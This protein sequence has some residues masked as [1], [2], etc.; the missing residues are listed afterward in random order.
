MNDFGEMLRSIGYFHKKNI[1]ASN[2]LLIKGVA[3]DN[4]M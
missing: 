4:I 3:F 1:F 2:R